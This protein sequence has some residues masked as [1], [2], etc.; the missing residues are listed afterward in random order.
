MIQHV[1]RSFIAITMTMLTLVLLV[2]L[3]ALNL[4]T[5]ALTYNQTQKLL[6]QI[7][8]TEVYI[9]DPPEHEF[10]ENNPTEAQN[11][12]IGKQFQHTTTVTTTVCETT[13][14]TTT[15]T[16]ANIAYESAVQP[17]DGTTAPAPEQPK[18]Q[19]HPETRRTETFR[20]SE[21]TQI[22]T[23]PTPAFTRPPEPEEP[24]WES[25]P[26]YTEPSPIWTRPPWEDFEEQKPD[27]DDN[28]DYDEH[29]YPNDN[30]P[31]NNWGA[32]LSPLYNLHMTHFLTQSVLSNVHLQQNTD[33]AEQTIS[34]QSTIIT[35]EQSH[36]IAE[37][38][39]NIAH[40][41]QKPPMDN[42]NSIDHFVVY[43]N[44]TGAVTEVHGTDL[45]DT[46]SCAE[47]IA[48]VDDSKQYD[49][50]CGTLQFVKKDYSKGSVVVFSDRQ[51]DRTMLK[52]LLF[53]SIGVFVLMEFIVFFLTK[54]LTK[55]AMRPMQ[56]SLEKQQQFISDAGHELKTPLTIISANADILSDEIGE[57]KWLSYIKSQAER[58]RILVQEMMDL[59]KIS[60]TQQQLAQSHFNISSLVENV[61]LP[62]EC[63]AFE[64]QK[65]FHIEIQPGIEFF[66]NTEQIRRMVGIF[67]DNAFKYSDANGTIQVQLKTE[68][69]KKILKIYNTGIGI[70]K[71]EEEKIFERFYR[72]DSS[73]SRQT[74]GYGL[75]LAIAKSIAD[76]HHIK[77]Q[78]LTEPGQWIS[79]NLTL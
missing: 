31:W 7:A 64:Q 36:M 68:N 52:N 14:V 43:L 26:A 61:A 5:S 44:E 58:M 53:V 27:D 70:E 34:Y 66:G 42:R 40:R 29:L 2:P 20:A 10:D 23:Q 37:K 12:G 39:L 33:T 19:T 75:G 56:V 67:I 25:R 1:R 62:F 45:Y 17:A 63:Q 65:T 73:R 32:V 30:V 18:E 21:K 59:M 49:G 9:L 50:Y 3:C 51:S 54:V 35:T 79:F 55:R 46:A 4:I 16:T 78:V 6:E 15:T 60:S 48:Y 74:G 57:N 77:I 38:K 71:G 8:Q 11:V 13:T 22:V 28:D 76:Q 24:N 41:R 69:G 47:L 72:S